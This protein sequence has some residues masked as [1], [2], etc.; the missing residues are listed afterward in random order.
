MNPTDTEIDFDLTAWEGDAQE[1]AQNYGEF[2]RSTCVDP[3]NPTDRERRV[4]D[5]FAD[6]TGL[7][8]AD[9]G[10]I[11]RAVRRRIQE[12]QQLQDNA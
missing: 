3:F 10:S 11:E 1:L 12:R 4:L 5:G 6:S 7:G 9:Q 2:Y 8:L